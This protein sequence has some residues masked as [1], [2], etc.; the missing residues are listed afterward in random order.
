MLCALLLATLLPAF[1]VCAGG[2]TVVVGDVASDA[3]DAESISFSFLSLSLLSFFFLS[4]LSFFF[5]CV[6]GLGVLTVGGGSNG[7]L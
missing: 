7:M 1:A 4:F 3:D 5:S 2:R 6:G